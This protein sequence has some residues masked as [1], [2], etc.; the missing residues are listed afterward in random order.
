MSQIQQFFGCETRQFTLT[1]LT[2]EHAVGSFKLPAGRAITLIP[3]AA[4]ELRAP[5]GRAWVTFTGAAGD[6]SA[7]GGDH[8]VNAAQALR[9]KAGQ[10]LVMEALGSPTDALYFNVVIDARSLVKPVSPAVT[11]RLMLVW[12]SGHVGTTLERMAARLFGLA[13]SAR[14]YGQTGLRPSAKGALVCQS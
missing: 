12:A 9:F 11:P 13:Q 8:F 14:A 3:Q 6:I 1:R 2:P 10:T 4:G 5:H 7:V